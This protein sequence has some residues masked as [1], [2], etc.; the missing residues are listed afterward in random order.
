V[1][2][3]ST[4]LDEQVKK[5]KLT[6]QIFAKLVDFV[7]TGN[8]KSKSHFESVKEVK[9][10]E[11]RVKEIELELF[12][13]DIGLSATK[14]RQALSWHKKEVLNLHQDY[15]KLKQKKASK[16]IPS[17]DGLNAWPVMNVNHLLAHLK[18]ISKES[19]LEKFKTEFTSFTHDKNIDASEVF[20][21]KESVEK[22]ESN[23]NFQFK[24][25]GDAKVRLTTAAI[26]H[27]VDLIADAK[28]SE[29]KQKKIDSCVEYGHS[30]KS[31]WITEIKD[32]YRDEL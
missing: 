32:L 14:L 6:V 11:S 25:V 20:K 26:L 16:I 2:R 22:L 5:S 15:L 29:E 9:N 8:L 12:L 21:F 23:I 3:Y 13:R 24:Y 31:P 1:D 27:L 19:D 10:F 28:T 7:K 17:D 4:N 30:K 18:E